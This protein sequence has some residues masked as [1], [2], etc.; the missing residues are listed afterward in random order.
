[1]R[2]EKTTEIA[3][4]PDLVW[5]VQ[6]DID[7]WPEWTPSVR[8]AQ[9]LEPGPL[10]VGSTA[11]LEQPRLRPTVWRVT[12]LEAGRGF[13]WVSRSPGVRS[14][15][16]HWIVPLPDGG[17]RVELALDLSGPLG[18][19]LGWLYGDLVRRYIGME[20]DGLKRRCERG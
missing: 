14:T 12:E 3:A 19:L 5:A 6:S 10:A 1:M 16:E 2:F 17:V 13:V 9:R 7:R 18:P 11:R 8:R 4:D 15:G 20:A